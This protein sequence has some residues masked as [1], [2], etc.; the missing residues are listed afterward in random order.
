MDDFREEILE[1]FCRESKEQKPGKS[2]HLLVTLQ[3]ELIG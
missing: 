1:E 2:E 3:Q